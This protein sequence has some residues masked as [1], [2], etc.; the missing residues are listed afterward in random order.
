MVILRKKQ[1][2]TKG[3]EG[4]EGSAIV[5]AYSHPFSSLLRSQELA[6]A[7]LIRSSS[8]TKRVLQFLETRFEVRQSSVM[9]AGMSRLIRGVGLRLLRRALGGHVLVVS[10]QD[11]ED[12]YK[13][14]SEEKCFDRLRNVANAA[15]RLFDFL[16]N[17]ANHGFPQSNK[18]SG[19]VEQFKRFRPLAFKGSF[20]PLVRKDW[21]REMK[22]TFTFIEC[23]EA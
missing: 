9:S 5:V 20:N 4:E 18:I 1:E 17:A 16:V 2:I 10:R 6:F 11:K 12:P 13:D 14:P 23:T 21:I 8:L 22:K 19:V 3:K 15:I 7:I